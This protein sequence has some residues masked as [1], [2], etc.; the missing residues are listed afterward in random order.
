M[1][2]GVGLDYVFM[3]LKVSGSGQSVLTAS[4]QGLTSSQVDLH[5]A[6]SP[7][8]DQ[9]TAYISKATPYGT[10]TMYSNGTATMLLSVSFLGQP[11]QNM[12][13]DWLATR[14]AVSPRFTK[15]GS[16]GTTST[17]F[18]PDTT[19]SA[20]ITMLASSP[21]TGPISQTH[22]ILV[23][24]APTPPARTPLQV[25]ESFW[26]LIVVAVVVVFVGAFYLFRMRTK[27]QRA[28]IEAGFE[29]V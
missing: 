1:S 9:L 26:Y 12:T 24:Q 5:L 25:I 3:H 8:V 16:S 11:V 6:D 22:F 29:V 17:V 27:K 23:L 14:G 13:V 19:G 28:E 2:I 15:T 4:A 10:G 21:L 18:T 20:N 7:L